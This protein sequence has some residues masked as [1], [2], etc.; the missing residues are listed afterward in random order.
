MSI[1][2]VHRPTHALVLVRLL[3]LPSSRVVVVVMVVVWLHTHVSHV[4]HTVEKMARTAIAL[5]LPLG[6]RMTLDEVRAS[7]SVRMCG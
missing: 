3:S 7:T 4:A 2:A 5:S 1:T 6:A